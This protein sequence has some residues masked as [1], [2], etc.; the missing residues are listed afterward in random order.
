MEPMNWLFVGGYDPAYPRNA[1]LRKGLL[2][3]GETVVEKAS[4][5]SLK[6][7]VRYPALAARLALG[8]GHPLRRADVLYVPAFG[9]KDVPLARLLAFASARTVVFDP[10][11][12]RYETKILDRGRRSPDSLAALWNK[13]IDA[14]AFRLADVVLADTVAHAARYAEAYGVPGRKL[15]VVPVGYDDTLFDPGFAPRAPASGPFTVLFFGSFL[16]LHGVDAVVE[17]ARAVLDRDPS[18]RFR[19]VGSGDTWSRAKALAA[20]LGASNCV[21][22]PWAPA[23]SLPGIIASADIALG[24][25]GRTAKARRVVPHK[26]FQSLGMRRPVITAR[27][28]AEEE[29]FVHGEDIWLCGEPF[30]ETLAEAV[31]GLKADPGLRERLAANGHRKV[32][33]RYTPAAVASILRDAVLAVRRERRA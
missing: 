25:F 28:A 14:A 30:P 27:T 29:L 1:V 13:W 8:P 10:L 26:V 33:E 3:L 9:Q 24:V 5:R 22:L 7:W 20:G 19:F 23:A 11:A 15:V 31:L 18:I 2:A 32:C 21:F 17:A 12:D 6:S 4:P 16:P